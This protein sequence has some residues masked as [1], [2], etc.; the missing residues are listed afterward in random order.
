MPVVRA[1]WICRRYIP[2]LWPGRSGCS[3]NTAGR[4]MNGPPSSGQVV[5]AGR[6]SSRTSLVTTSPT[7][8]RSPRRS[9]IRSSSAPTSR[10][11][12][13]RDGV[14]GIKV[15]I[16]STRRR[17]SRWGRSPK[18]SSARRA[19]P[20][21][22]VTTGKSAS[23]TFV[24]SNAGPPAATTRRWISAASSD[25]STGTETSTR[26]RSRRRRSRNARRSGKDIVQEGR[27]EGGPPRPPSPGACAQEPAPQHGTDSRRGSAGRRAEPPSGDYPAT[28][29]SP[30]PLR[31]PWRGCRTP[32]PGTGTGRG[33]ET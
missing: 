25:R 22:L 17:I 18:A 33:T 30:R 16:S 26:S 4:V 10:A 14:G 8:P 5:S 29:P 23:A 32:A 1:S 9:P 6:R 27:I 28:A 20:S 31:S 7:G 24:N 21:R 12:H 3:V 11:A 13:S 15:S 19:V 2:R